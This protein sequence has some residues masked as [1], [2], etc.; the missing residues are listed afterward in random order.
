MMA[1]DHNNPKPNKKTWSKPVIQGLTTDGPPICNPSF[2]Q[3]QVCA[4]N[5]LVQS[6]TACNQKGVFS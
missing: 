4:S 1:T 2:P 3:A 5:G 6:G